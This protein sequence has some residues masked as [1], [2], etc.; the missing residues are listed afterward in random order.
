MLTNDDRGHPPM[1]PRGLI[2]ERQS[3]F[4]M[5]ASLHDHS[6]GHQM[7]FPSAHIFG[8]NSAATTPKTSCPRVEVLRF[9][10]FKLYYT[11][12]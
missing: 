1:V 5:N 7:A 9:A 11:T 6:K 3:V 4:I 2:S 12:M 8:P 10:A